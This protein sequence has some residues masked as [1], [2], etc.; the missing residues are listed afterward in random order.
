M[1]VLT[2]GHYL[3]LDLNI[4]AEYRRRVGLE[5]AQQLVRGWSN[6]P[7]AHQC[8]FSSGFIVFL[9]V[10]FFIYLYLYI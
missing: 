7:P 8:V 9:E 4:C 2:H 10:V 3:P 1:R 5:Q 6:Q